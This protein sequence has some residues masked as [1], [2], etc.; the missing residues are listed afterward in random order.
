MSPLS[1]LLSPT[2]KR[3]GIHGA[4]RDVQVAEVFAEVVGPALAPHCKALRI[5]RGALVIF[6]ANPALAQQLHLESERIVPA[7]NQGLGADLVTKLRFASS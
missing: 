2:L 3:M 5:S 7:V 6:C 1:E 4:V